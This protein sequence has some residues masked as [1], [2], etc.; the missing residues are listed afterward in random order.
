[1][2]V[3]VEMKSLDRSVRK[4]TNAFTIK[5]LIGNLE[6]IHWIKYGNKWLHLVSET[7][8]TLES[9]SNRF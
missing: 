2:S 9:L 7:N 6:V 3:E 5:K 1:M 4:T 8:H